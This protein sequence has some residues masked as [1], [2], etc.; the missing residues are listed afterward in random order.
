MTVSRFEFAHVA[1]P[2]RSVYRHRYLPFHSRF[3]EGLHSDSE[4][5]VYISLTSGRVLQLLRELWTRA[6][7]QHARVGGAAVDV[8]DLRREYIRIKMV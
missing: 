8:A 6:D 2:R 1:N 7:V 4:L 5:H 3:R